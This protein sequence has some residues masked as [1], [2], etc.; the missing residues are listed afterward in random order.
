MKRMSLVIG[1][2]TAG[3][4]SFGQSVPDNLDI[5]I[6]N[7][8]AHGSNPASGA[9]IELSLRPKIATYSPPPSQPV[10]ED[11]GVILMAPVSDFSLLDN[12]IIS[13]ANPAIY[14]S[15][16]TTVMVPQGAFEIGDGNIYW[17]M[18]LNNAG[19][20]DLSS[21]TLNNWAFTFTIS[22]NNPKTPEQFR[23]VRIVDH[24]NN[25]AL[26]A[27]F[28]A[29]VFSYLNV[30]SINQLQGTSFTALPVN[31][32]NFSGYKMGNK[33]VL[34]WTTSNEQNNLGFE[35]QRATDGTNY[36]AIGFVNSQAGGGNSVPDISYVFDDNAPAA[37]KKNYYRLNQ[38]DINGRSKLSNVVV[39]SGDKPTSVGIGG[40][41]PNPAATLVNVIVDAPKRDNVTLVVTDVNG[42]TVKQQLANVEEGSNT[43]PVEISS[44]AQGSYLVKVVC[45]SGCETTVAKF[46]KQ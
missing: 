27:Y 36:S 22:F 24:T 28:G 23:K 37:S 16:A 15:T 45:K 42:K 18:A 44:F 35:I 21:L 13:Q 30:A 43:I 46:N 39:I 34:R 38:K 7:N 10:A 12:V 41:F 4:F 11:Y 1:A 14:G 29:T 3:I 40:L 31:L 8:G 20:M 19:G 5:G 25:A 32:L 6:F 26:S 9:C 2:V 33:N 17:P